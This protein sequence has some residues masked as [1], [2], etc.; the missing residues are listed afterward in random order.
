[1]YARACCVLSHFSCVQLFATPWIIAHQAP[2]S[3]WFSRQEYWSGLPCPFP[4]DLPDPG[5]EYRSPTL[6]ADSLPFKPPGKP[7]WFTIKWL[8]IGT[9]K[10]ECR[11]NKGKQEGGHNCQKC[12]PGTVIR[13][14]SLTSWRPNPFNYSPVYTK[15]DLDKAWKWGFNRDLGGH[16]SESESRLV[17]S[18]SLQSH[19]L[20]SPWIS[21]GQN[22]SG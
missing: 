17:M 12:E 14:L 5:I 11:D 16:E 18:D 20:Y 8:I 15:E 21:P 1:M 6:Q 3:M 10:G 7:K 4:G 19:G 2:L 13:Q 22:R 9:L